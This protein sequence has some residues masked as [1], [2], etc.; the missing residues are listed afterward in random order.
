M[1]HTAFVLA[2]YGAAV[3]VLGIVFAWLLID[4]ATTRREL[5]RL[6]AAG[7]RRRSD[8]ADGDTTS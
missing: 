4:R 6:Q 7:M 2:S 5:E 1:S 3:L 8:A